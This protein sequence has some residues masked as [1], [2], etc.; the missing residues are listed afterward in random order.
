MDFNKPI[1]WRIMNFIVLTECLFYINLTKTTFCIGLPRVYSE[2][3]NIKYIW[4]SELKSKKKLTALRE[5]FKLKLC[6]ID[7]LNEKSLTNSIPSRLHYNRM[8]PFWKSKPYPVIYKIWN[9][10]TIVK[11]KSH[12]GISFLSI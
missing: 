1:S 8:L 2:N 5:L 7:F 11:P 12:V 9:L 3:W 10:K 4:I 6:H